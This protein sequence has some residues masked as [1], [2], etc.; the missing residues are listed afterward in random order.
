MNIFFALSHTH[1]QALCALLCVCAA[2]KSARSPCAL[3]PSTLDALR[4]SKVYP[5]LGTWN[6][7]L[8]YTLANRTHTPKPL[9]KHTHTHTH[10][11]PASAPSSRSQLLFIYF[12]APH[13]TTTT[14][15]TSRTAVQLA[16]VG[17]SVYEFCILG[18]LVCAPAK[19]I[20]TA[21]PEVAGS[22]LTTS[23]AFCFCICLREP[24]LA[25]RAFFNEFLTICLHKLIVN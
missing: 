17:E 22:V 19:S 14:F 20:L 2:N 6:R 16:R 12:C 25:L 15:A 21:P 11:H 1:S 4:T 23:P 18:L 8:F 13:F 10:I 24:Q 7:K 9:F 5:H 3:L